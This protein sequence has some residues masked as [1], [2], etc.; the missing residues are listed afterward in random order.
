MDLGLISVRYARALLKASVEA[1][2]SDKVYAD[3]QTLAASYAE[4]SALRA[5]IDNPMLSKNQKGDLLAAAMGGTSCELTKRFIGLVLDEGRE[6]I[7]Q[8]IAN[9]FIT[10]YRKQNNLIKARLVTASAPSQQVEAHLKQLVG[11]KTSG[12]KVEFV[13][14][15][16]PDIIG[17]FVLEYD[18]YRM[19]AS[20]KTQLS[21][22]LSKLK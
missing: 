5:T 1:Q 2:N 16:D 22:I 8:F 15:V 12:S 11:S 13:S 21:A 18:T 4:V 6:N 20:I 19:D 7:M 10:L 9:S 3:M 17:G 14:E